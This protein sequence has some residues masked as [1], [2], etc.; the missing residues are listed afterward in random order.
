MGTVAPIVMSAIVFAGSA[1]FAATA[2][3]AAGGGAVAAVVAGLLLNARYGPM[4]VALASSLSGSALR[5][6]AHGQAMIDASWAMASRGEGR[7]DPAFM[8]GATLPSY[9]AWVGGTAIGV[10]AGELIGDPEALGL[11][12][13]FPAFF[14]ALLVQGE[15][16]PGRLAVVAALLGASVALALVPF[17]PPGV[18]V[19]SACVAALIGL[20]GSWRRAGA[21]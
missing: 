8:V 16:Q 19:I 10:F 18:P 13:L 15:L 2:V 5:R 14:L 17:T 21:D 4:G 7:F 11:D 1:Q 6:A 20:K 12:A 9:P 3:L